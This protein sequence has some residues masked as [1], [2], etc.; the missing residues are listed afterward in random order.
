MSIMIRFRCLPGLLAIFLLAFST[1]A[2]SQDYED[3]ITDYSEKFLA[4]SQTFVKLASQNLDIETDYDAALA[5]S[6]IA[7]EFHLHASYLGDFLL[8][9]KI[10]EKSGQ[11][12]ELGA[13]LVK[14]RI[15]NVI[16]KIPQANERMASAAADVENKSIIA[17]AA[18]LRQDLTALQQ[19]LEGIYS[20]Y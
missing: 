13:R 10:L 16:N 8:M 14:L 4:Y 7:D 19:L 20:S 9:L 11:G 18:D 17:K 3:T 15:R 5:F 6:N 12:K 1:P 2:S